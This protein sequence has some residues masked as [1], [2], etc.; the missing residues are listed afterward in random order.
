MLAARS[1]TTTESGTTVR[2]LLWMAKHV[3]GSD[4]RREQKGSGRHGFPT[5]SAMELLGEA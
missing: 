4:L 3:T 1:M 2:S 5:S